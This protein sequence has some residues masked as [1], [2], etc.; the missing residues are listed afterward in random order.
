MLLKVNLGYVSGLI[1][2]RQFVRICIFKFQ[3]VLNNFIKTTESNIMKQ[4]I[5]SY[6]DCERSC[7]S[8]ILKNT[9]YKVT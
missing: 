1:Y 8:D 9:N 5:C 4:T 6:L 3:D 7:E 2:Y